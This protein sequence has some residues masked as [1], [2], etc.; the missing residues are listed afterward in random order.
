MPNASSSPD[1]SPGPTAT[2][3]AETRA[4]IWSLTPEQAGEILEQ[5]A[6]DFRPRA[7]IAP[8]N[9]HD[10]ALRLEELSSDPSF[11]GRLVSGNIDARREWD[12]LVELK[13]L[14]DT[15][16]AAADPALLVD[17]TVGDSS[18][19]RRNQISIGSDMLARG[20]A[21]ELVE[22][23]MS[24]QPFQLPARDV[25]IARQAVS[26]A[27]NDPN[28]HLDYWPERS[29]EDQI[30]YLQIISTAEPI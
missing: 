30:Y 4:D 21:P 6:L 10:A 17:V 2:E 24:N 29:R 9:A 20:V 18:L 15:A 12:E 1:F 19:T 8:Q 14:G 16:D 28:F 22:R 5:R 11:R 25:A 13:S 23:I 26:Q 3:S 7:P 27:L